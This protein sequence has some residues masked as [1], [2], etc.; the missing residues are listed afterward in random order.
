[1]NKLPD[2]IIKKASKGLSYISHPLRIRILEYLDVFGSSSVS[3]I[4]KALNQEQMIIS[5]HLKKLKDANLIK[6]TRK[7]IFVYYEIYKEYPAS[8]FKCIRKLFA[9]ITN[10][11]KYINESFKELL[12]EDYMVMV[13]GRIKLFANLDKIKILNYILE[14]GE[15]YVS[16]IV[17]KTKIKQAKVSLY[18]KRLYEDNFLKSHRNGRF[19]YYDITKGV[20]KTALQCI[21]NRYDKYKDNF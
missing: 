14:N 18:L 12:P 10:N 1:M 4:T 5:Q 6:S 19:I 8:I 2:D 21:H 11:E 7:G 13:A 17:N 20:H 15:S 16:Q 9:V 3:D